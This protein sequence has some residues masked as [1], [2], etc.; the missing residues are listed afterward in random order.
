MKS[1]LVILSL[2]MISIVAKCQ[3][4]FQ[5]G[6]VVNYKHDTLR[7][8]LESS[9]E[10]NLFKRVKFK[11]E[12]NGSSR[13][14]T[15]TDIVSFFFSGD[16]FRTVAFLNTAKENPEKDLSFAKQLVTGTFELYT[17]VDAERRF[18][19]A[20]R[21][22]S[23]A[24]L[25]DAA[26]GSAN[27]PVQPGNY[28]SRLTL[29]AN[30]CKSVVSSLQVVGYSQHDMTGFFVKLNNCVSPGSSRS[31]YQKPKI[32]THVFAYVGALPMGEN[33]QFYG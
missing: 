1:A 7:G 9:T 32:V 21:D 8:Y 6:Y 11:S 2:F 25:Y 33:S 20:K 15:K 16:L 19:I 22:T 13:I 5:P 27:E 31:L 28:M 14:F 29:M 4:E 12:L 26:Y 30:E 18:Y 10:S 17:F 23:A 3:T 24:L